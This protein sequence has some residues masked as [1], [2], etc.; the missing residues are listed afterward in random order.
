M[1][2]EE[3]SERMREEGASEVRVLIDP[4]LSAAS[5]D[6][7]LPFDEEFVHPPIHNTLH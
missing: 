4:L 7:R 1:A 3:Q 5:I 2:D 6:A